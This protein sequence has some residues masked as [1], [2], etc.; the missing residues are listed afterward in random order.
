MKIEK[1]RIYEGRNIYSHSPCIRADIDLE[2]YTDVPTCN[3]TNFNNLLLEY[4][5]T[6]KE[7]K[8]S[9][10][11][12]GGFVE[13]LYEGTYMAHV[14]EHMCIEIQNLLGYSVA[15]GKARV[16]DKENIYSV[17]FEYKCKT[18]GSEAL[19]LAF[20]L[21]ND[22]CNG[23]KNIN[24]NNKL[25]EIKKK[26]AKEELGPSTKAIKEEAIRRGIPVMEIGTGSLLQLGYGS[27]NKRVQATITENTGCIPVDISCNKELTKELLE[28]AGIPTPKGS[29][30]NS[31][32]DILDYINIIGYPVVIKPN[33]G[34]KGKGISLNLKNEVEVLSAFNIA[35]KYS[36]DIIVERFIEGKSYRMLVVNGKVVACAERTPPHVIGDGKNSI[37]ELIEIENNNPLRGDDH[38]KALTKIK[39]DTIMEL[40]LKRQ[41]FDL[42]Y[43]P[44][45]GEKIFLRVNDNLSTGGT[46]IDV[47]DKIHPLNALIGVNAANIIGLDI[48]GID[49]VTKDI[50]YPMVE[51]NGVVIEVNSAPGIRMH[52]YP[53]VGKKRNVAKDIVDMLFPED[54]KY[55]I[56]IISVTGTNGKTTTSRM[57]AKILEKKGYSVGLTSTGGVYINDKCIVKGDT[58]GAL[59]AKSILMDKRVEAAVLETA[60]GGLINKGLGYDLADVGI[61]TNI[62]ED[63]LG[64]DGINSLDQLAYVKSLVVEAIK[65]NGYAVLN[66][67]D[68]YCVEIGKELKSDIIYFSTV[69]ENSIIQDQ[70]NR[71]KKAV[72]IKGKDIFIF[73]GV[74]ENKLLSIR[75]IPATLKGILSYNISNSLSAIAG[76]LGLGI[77]FKYIIEGLREFESN[78]EYNPGRFNVYNVKDFKVV[79]DY[80]HNI[81]GYKETIKS[82]KNMNPKRIIG[83]IGVP[84]DRTETSIV[85]IGQLCAKDINNIIIKED[86]DSRGREIGGVANLLMK[87]CIIGGVDKNNIE[88]ELCEELALKKAMLMAGE[89]DIVVVFYEDYDGIIKTIKEVS[90]SLGHIT[91]ELKQNA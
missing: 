14:I 83:V 85:R 8:C 20:N 33:D 26:V 41:N 76:A 21:V 38:E 24:F 13:R 65:K 36:D 50:S 81:E 9:R 1:L 48:A 37:V 68:K 52:H 45:I 54:S 64:I 32:E 55:S 7:H 91:D 17:I 29:V 34:N 86:K 69:F 80:G 74:K 43:V 53:T 88:I 67:E 77:E 6:L 30:Y 66:G 35:K 72:Y 63:H 25:E 16:T 19:N 87:G 31:I 47:T 59:S 12:R 22:I 82:L 4:M 84:G 15:F 10:G 49:M 90:D 11:Y 70:I 44:S 75:D 60:R 46:A 42:N 51:S 27:Y 58:T 23:I 61:I 57:L 40:H 3:I 79:V 5:P 39:V 78:E 2:K 18:A 71:G 62:S 89:N 28:I 56:P 73:D